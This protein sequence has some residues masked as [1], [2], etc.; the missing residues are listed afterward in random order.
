MGAEGD[1][2]AAMDTYKGLAGR[3]E[4]DGIHGTGVRTGPAADT[5]VL[6]DDD[7]SAF[8]VRVSACRAGIG[9]GSRVAGEADPRLKARRKSTR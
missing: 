3:I 5:E 6:S 7:A 4:I 9:A 8:A 2:P 1:T